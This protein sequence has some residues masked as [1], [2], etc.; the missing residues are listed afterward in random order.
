M[1]EIFS[2]YRPILRDKLSLILLL[3]ACLENTGVNVMWTYYGAFY[4]QQH[5]FGVEQ[6]GWV[7]L[8]AG[9]GV[10]LGQTP[11]GSQFGER[12]RLLFIVDST[13]SGSLI[14]LSVMLAITSSA[15]ITFMAL[16]W[17]LHGLVM[18]STVVLLVGQSPAGRGTTLSFYGSVMSF[19]MAMGAVLG[20]LVL[21]IAGFFLLGVCTLI[22]PTASAVLMTFWARPPPVSPPST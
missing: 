22:L 20:G 21:A 2:A 19:G 7:S 18:V 15:A 12:P 16:G 8:A 17:L 13:G 5:G 3:P 4:V 9:L 11:A 6:V 14:G 1:S 10:L